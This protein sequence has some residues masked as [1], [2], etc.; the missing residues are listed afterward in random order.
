MDSGDED[1]GCDRNTSAIDETNQKKLKQLQQ[2]LVTTFL[3]LAKEKQKLSEDNV[4][5][6]GD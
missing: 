1:N 3:E 5:E 4:T 6:S 2:Q